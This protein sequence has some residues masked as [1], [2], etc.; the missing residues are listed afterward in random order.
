MP[1]HTIMQPSLVGMGGVVGLAS[2]VGVAFS[3]KNKEWKL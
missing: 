1:C 2:V 3:I